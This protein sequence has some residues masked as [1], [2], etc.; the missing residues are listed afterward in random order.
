MLKHL[1]EKDY[2]LVL[3]V[4]LYQ[5][6]ELSQGFDRGGRK[7]KGA[8]ILIKEHIQKRKSTSSTSHGRS[9]FS[10]QNCAGATTMRAEF[11]QRRA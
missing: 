10:S 1:L 6:G 3:A 11:N 2:N 5:R 4:R 7:I 9:S 8:V